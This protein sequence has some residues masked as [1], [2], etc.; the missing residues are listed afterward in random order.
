M[1]WFGIDPGVTTGLAWWDDES[2]DELSGHEEVRASVGGGSGSGGSGSGSGGS[3]VL[4]YNAGMREAAFK[5]AQLVAVFGPDV[6]VIEDFLL[7][8][9]GGGPRSSSRA[10]LAPVLMTG[11]LL[12]WIEDVL[13]E[14][15][16]EGEIRFQSAADAKHVINDKRLRDRGWWIKGRQHSRDAARHVALAYRK[17]HSI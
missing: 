14:E 9:G 1:R 10:G 12:V 7:R 15:R 8:L 17:E 6:V 11:M 16:W 5:I 13:S 4:E 2:G 3:G